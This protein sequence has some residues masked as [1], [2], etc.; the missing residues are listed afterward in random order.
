ML[1]PQRNRFIFIFVAPTKLEAS[2]PRTHL[3]FL[4]GLDQSDVDR[5]D[6]EHEAQSRKDRG[7]QVLIEHIHSD[8]DVQGNGP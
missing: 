4:Q 5:Y 7:S 3:Y 6:N 2:L 8:D 1:L